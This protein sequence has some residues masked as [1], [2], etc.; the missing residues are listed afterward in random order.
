MHVA[1]TDELAG[2]DHG[3]NDEGGDENEKVSEEA[4]EG[5][6]DEVAEEAIAGEGLKISAAAGVPSEVFRK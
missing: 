2:D 4:G 1:A 5:G 3:N 6:N